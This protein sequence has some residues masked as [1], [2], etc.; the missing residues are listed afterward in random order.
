L[1][2]LKR[3]RATTIGDGAV[4]RGIL[5]TLFDLALLLLAFGKQLLLPLVACRIEPFS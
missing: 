5:R 3:T 2:L 1:D 4:R